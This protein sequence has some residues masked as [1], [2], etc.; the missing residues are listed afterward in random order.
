MNPPSFRVILPS[1][2]PQLGS[3]AKIVVS[4]I[5]SVEGVVTSILFT[6][7]YPKVHCLLSFTPTWYL[8]PA[9]IESVLPPTPESP[10]LNVWEPPVGFDSASS[11]PFSLYIWYTYGAEPP[12]AVTSIS[13]LQIASTVKF[14]AVG[15]VIDTTGE[16]ISHPFD[17]VLNM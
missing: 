6:A 9:A 17:V 3:T 8:L 12:V 13:V 10:L 5:V 1:F 4:L 16:S 7:G 2:C 11:K 15:P 14:T